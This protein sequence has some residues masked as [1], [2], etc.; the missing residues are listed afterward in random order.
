MTRPRANTR[1]IVASFL[2]ALFTRPGAPFPG[3]GRCAGTRVP[4]NGA[5]LMRD[6]PPTCTPFL[7]VRACPD[8]GEDAMVRER[9][10]G[11]WM[12]GPYLWVCESCGSRKSGE[13][14]FDAELYPP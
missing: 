5:S 8:C 14:G 2:C 1:G 9:E 13:A 4:P 12:N 7:Y 6:S 11:Y 10:P 3:A